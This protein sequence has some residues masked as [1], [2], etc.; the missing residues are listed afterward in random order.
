MTDE[1]FESYMRDVSRA[2]NTA[3]AYKRSTGITQ[4]DRDALLE[5]QGGRCAI[6]QTD[7]PGT[8]KGWQL[9]HDHECCAPGTKRC[10]K[11]NRGLLCHACNVGLGFFRDSDHLLNAALEYLSDHRFFRNYIE[12]GYAGV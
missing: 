4:Q 6:C 12:K 2:A 9:D 10:G 3:V 7:N 8:S 1:E 11:C 5:A